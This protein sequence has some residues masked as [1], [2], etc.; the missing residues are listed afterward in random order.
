[1]V[2]APRLLALLAVAALLLVPAGGASAGTGG[3]APPDDGMSAPPLFATGGAAYLPRTAKPKP[4]HKATARPRPRP[5]RKPAPKRHRR[6]AARPHHRP[7]A[8]PKPKPRPKPKPAS[9]PKPPQRPAGGS[10]PAMPG[11]LPGVFPIAGYH[12]FGGRDARFNAART[13]HRHQGQDVLA[14]QGTPL[15]SPRAGTVTYRAYQRGG[16]GFYLVIR[17][18]HADRDY[19]F[20]HL[21]KGSTLV[22]IGEHVSAGQQIAEVGESGDATGPHLHFEIWVDGG[23]YTG[24]HPIDPLPQLRRWDR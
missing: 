7:A 2:A 21:R 18:A 14:A 1:M 12:T 6:P 22:S 23:W 3:A 13:G 8:K 10:A 24:G 19:F 5:K 15:R 4:K 20:A 11:T 17:D 9:P 16:A